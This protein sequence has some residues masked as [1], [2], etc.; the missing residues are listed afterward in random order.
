[1]Q[2]TLYSFDFDDTLC[3][4][5]RPEIGKDTWKDK[6][7]IDWPYAGWWGKSESIDP[8]IFYVPRNEWVYKKYLESSSDEN[9]LKILATGRLNKVPNM[10][11]H[12]KEILRKNNLEFDEVLLIPGTDSYPTNGEEGIYLNWGGDTF[13]FKTK[14]FE[15]LIKKTK[16][17]HFVMYDDRHLHITEFREWAKKI[18]CKVTIVD[19]VNKR[20]YK[21]NF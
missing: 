1:M 7:G 21:I 14:L 5:P 12:V 6:T 20:E 9:G 16:C 3:H 2:K 11:N 4:T 13:R 15:Q 10:R 17:D 8:E 19:V 18:N